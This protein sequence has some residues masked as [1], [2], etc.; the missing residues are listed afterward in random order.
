MTIDNLNRDAVQ[1]LLQDAEHALTLTVFG[2]QKGN[3]YVVRDTIVSARR[4]YDD[5]LRRATPLIL[6]DEEMVAFR[7]TMERLTAS[8]RV[9]GDRV[10]RKSVG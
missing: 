4:M 5:L 10:D 9:F 3:R 7:Y 8:L 6:S 1:R 2:D